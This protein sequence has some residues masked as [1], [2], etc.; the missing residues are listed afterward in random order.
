MPFYRCMVPNSGGGG[1]TE[2][3]EEG[4]FLEISSNMNSTGRLSLFNNTTFNSPVNIGSQTTDVS[5]IF[6]GKT[7]LNKPVSFDCNNLVSMNYTFNS[8]TNFN[9]P[10]NIP[11]S[12][13]YMI[14]T[15]NCCRVFNQP[16]NMPPNLLS[17]SN[18]FS[19]CNLFNQPVNFPGSVLDASCA[20]VSCSNLNQPVNLGNGI[21]NVANM[22]R[23][24]NL[25][26]Q[27]VVIP[28]SITNATDMFSYTNYNNRVDFPTNPV[29]YISMYNLFKGSPWFDQPVILTNPSNLENTF[30]AMTRFN[31][32]V[33]VRGV[34]DSNCP[35]NLF[36]MYG[37]FYASYNF[38]ST[39]I[40][41][42][43]LTS[44]NIVDERWAKNCIP[45]NSQR[46]YTSPINIY[47]DGALFNY[48]ISPSTASMG[49]FF[50]AAITWT[51]M[52]NGYYNSAYNFYIY[53]NVADGKN[54]FNNYWHDIYN[55]YPD[56]E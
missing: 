36:F 54:W 29:S 15:F 33:L 53:N 10:V 4:I 41:D 31:S 47:A 21:Q 16:V 50:E 49:Y 28:N 23:S 40:F 8:C 30:S 48:I 46:T 37:M 35:L 6:S 1:G 12:V 22:F 44:A 26:N 27:R 20:F 9:Q 52:T 2:P 14:Q 56:Y 7:L 43:D 34:Y 17:A 55:E 32:P 42:L 24:A 18:I 3:P 13:Q 51:A 45:V 25:F 38:H 11:A 5:Y 39:L 19:G